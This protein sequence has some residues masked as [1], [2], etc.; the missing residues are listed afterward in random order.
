MFS[1]SCARFGAVADPGENR[2]IG[3][4]RRCAAG[5]MS[6]HTLVAIRYSHVRSCERPWNPSNFD[7]ARSSV[8]C[9]ASSASK[10]EPSMR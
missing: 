2:S 8:S 3:R 6:R 10:A 4:A 5:A 1:S 9:T 7:Q